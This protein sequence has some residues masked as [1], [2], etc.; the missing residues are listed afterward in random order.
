M[1]KGVTIQDIA[2]ALKLSRNTVSKALSLLEVSL[3]VTPPEFLKAPF[4][5][6]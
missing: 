1:K 5:E 3:L 6:D 4:P 2:D